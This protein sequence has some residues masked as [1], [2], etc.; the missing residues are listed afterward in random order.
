[1]SIQ[2][3]HKQDIIAAVRKKGTTL[4]RLSLANG[5]SEDTLIK[6]LTR[7]WPNAHALIAAHL[8]VSKHD[9]WPQWYAKD[10][11]PR[12]RVRRDMQRSCVQR[13]PL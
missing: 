5:F 1:M 11:S 6:S 9:L 7:R 8:N 2:G 3:W 4:R 10:G 12:H 13:G